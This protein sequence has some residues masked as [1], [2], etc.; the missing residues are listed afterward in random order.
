MATREYLAD[1]KRQYST[2]IAR[3][4]AYRPALK[5]YFE[6]INSDVIAT[7][8]PARIACGAPDYI[9]SKDGIDV[10]YIEAK[11]IGVDLDRT[12]E[13]EQLTRYRESLENLI[14]T[15][16][17]EF[18]FYRNGEKT[19]E[20]RIASVQNGTIVIDV[21]QIEYLEALLGNFTRFS[22]QTIKSAKKLAEMMARKAR[23][24]RE[25]FFNVVE[26]NIDDDD[27]LPAQLRAFQA[28]LVHEMDTQQFSDV[29]AQTIAY[30]LFT[31]RLNDETPE[32]FSRSE[33]AELI[34]RSNPFLRQ[35]F[36][37]VAGPDLDHRVAWMVDA[38]CD[39]FRSTDM[40]AVLKDFGSGTGQN[41]PVLHFYETFLGEYDSSLRKAR[42]VWYTPEA[43]VSFIVRSIDV[44][45][46]SRFGIDKGISDDSKVTISVES[47]KRDRRTKSGVSMIEKKVHKV[48]LLDVAT[49]TG[50]F[51]AEA[52]KQIYSTFKGQEGV[53]SSYVEASLI[54]RMHGFELLMASYAMC[55]LKIDML[56]QETGYVPSDPRNP[57]RLSVYLTNSLEEHHPDVDTLFAAWLSKEANEASYIKKNMPIMVAFGNPPYSAISQ[58]KG[59]WITEKIEDYKYVNGEHFGERKH[60]LH[61]DY[62]KFIRLGE[63]YVDKSGHGILAYITNHSYLDNPTFRGMRWH[64]LRTFDEIYILDLHGSSKRYEA[65]PDGMSDKNVFD[66][67]QGVAITIGVKK[68]AK[69]GRRRPKLAS[70]KHADVWG[71][72][73]EKYSF[74]FENQLDSVDWTDLKM[75]E[76]FYF[77]RPLD[78]T[79]DVE[80]KKGISITDLFELR[81]TGVLT[82]R[83]GLTVGFTENELMEKIQRFSNPSVPEEDV[84]ESYFSKRKGPLPRGDTA[85]WKVQVARNAIRNF[86]HA[87]YAKRFCYRPF[88]DRCIYYANDLVHR[89]RD[90]VMKHMIT[91]DNVALVV[92]RQSICESWAH[93]FC[94]DYIADDSFVSNKSRERGYVIP[95][96]RFE[97]ILGGEPEKVHN[98]SPSAYDE[99]KKIAPSLNEQMLFDYIYAVLNSPRYR[100]VYEEFLKIDFP[101]IPLPDSEEYFI[102]LSDLGKEIRELH[103]GTSDDIRNRATTYPVDGNHK[104]TE[105]RFEE[106]K[107]WI[108]ETQY[109][110]GVSSGA[111]DYVVGSYQPARKWL[112]D[113][114]G[115][116]LSIGDI[117]HYQKIVTAMDKSIFVMSEIDGILAI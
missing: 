38:L 72:R 39:V 13:S 68:E 58:N 15:D 2:G 4:H 56:L 51:L 76:P 74:L 11:D 47:Q 32:N 35:L 61:D 111:W 17:L 99:F 62:V 89:V 106:G 12:E 23:L 59:D 102:R 44:V 71:N 112:K 77:F 109:F 69:T 116:C 92:C 46:K 9:L 8:D 117:D 52:I 94:T 82:A 3:E 64:L 114:R 53:W 43:V 95:L 57:P 115:R 87:E 7:N 67:Q 97:E 105:Y 90:E 81:V 83:D 93:A 60:W 20:V 48:Q 37:Y 31:A 33:A 30:G 78:L 104:V 22:G 41:D 110:G 100:D 85:V 113:R 65:V 107:V 18:R 42:G 6:S 86:E 88:D 103:V 16:Y 49:G 55:H 24:M 63:Y 91:G 108:N 70:V 34:P 84:R 80:Y 14:L 28:V 45:L 21:D 10:G 26:A 101:R 40:D 36:H 29:Y 25:I 98:F 75:N 1:V 27:G 96:Y 73:E 66:I 19:E 50:T 54:P 5:E 79:G